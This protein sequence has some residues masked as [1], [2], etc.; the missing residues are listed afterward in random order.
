MKFKYLLN[1][2]ALLPTAEF[3]NKKNKVKSEFAQYFQFCNG[4]KKFLFDLQ[5]QCTF[6][7]MKE[8]KAIKFPSSFLSQF[9]FYEDPL[10]SSRKESFLCA[11]TAAAVGNVAISS[12][13]TFFYKAILICLSRKMNMQ[14]QIDEAAALVKAERQSVGKEQWRTTAGRKCY[15]LMPSK[16]AVK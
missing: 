13:Y 10:E 5:A 7:R 6:V 8:E 4:R 12:K 2:T 3:R 9:L 14:K 11:A 15:P 16:C 1:S